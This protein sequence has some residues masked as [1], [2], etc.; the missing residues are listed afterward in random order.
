MKIHSVLII[1]L[2]LLSLI[3]GCKPLFM[4]IMKSGIANLSQCDIGSS[5]ANCRS[6]Q[7][8]CMGTYSEWENEKGKT[9]CSCCEEPDRG[10]DIYISR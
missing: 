8:G 10:S 5:A 9:E 2:L 1:I 7:S 6:I 3:S 4:S